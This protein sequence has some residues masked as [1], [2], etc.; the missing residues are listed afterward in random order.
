MAV[1]LARRDLEPARQHGARQRHDDQVPDLE[2][3]R[4]AHHPTR[5]RL[6]DLHVAPAH[7]LA[8]RVLLLLEVEDPPDHQGAGHVR[9]G[10]LQG[11]E[12]EAEERQPVGQLVDGQVGRQVD[13]LTKPRHRDP[14]HSSIPKARANRT[15]P[16]TMSRMSCTSCRNIN[17]RSIP[18]PNAT[19]E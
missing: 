8:V 11:L 12:L 3:E 6:A 5:L 16:S 9:A 10:R 2:V 7:R 18:M 13:V 1:G 4:P 14:H 19:P 17:V 15:S